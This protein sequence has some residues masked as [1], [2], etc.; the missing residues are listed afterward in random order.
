VNETWEKARSDAVGP[1]GKLL[2]L[3]NLV[4]GHRVLVVDE[5]WKKAAQGS[6]GRKES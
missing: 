2:L 1:A 6:E 4:T 5:T 3:R